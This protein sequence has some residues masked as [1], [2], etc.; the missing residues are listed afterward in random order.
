MQEKMKFDKEEGF[1][2]V[3]EIRKLWGKGN[4]KLQYQSG[5]DISTVRNC[6]LSAMNVD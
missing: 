2:K 1:K 6:T 5:Q 4:R 3:Q